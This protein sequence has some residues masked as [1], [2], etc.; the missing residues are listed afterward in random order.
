MPN[1]H[2][3]MVKNYGKWKYHEKVKPG[4]LKHVAES[5]DAIYTVRAGSP[6]TLSADTVRK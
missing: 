2:P 3:L 6:R 5:G 4:V 1:L